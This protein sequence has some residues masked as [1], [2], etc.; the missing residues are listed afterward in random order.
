MRD[1]RK[2]FPV[3][4]IDGMKINK[5]HFIDQDNSV[6]DALQESIA[7]QLSPLRYGVLPLSAAGEDSFNIKIAYDNQNSLRVSVLSCEAITSGGVRISLPGYI[8]ATNSNAGDTLTK[9]FSFSP[10]D[11]EGT[12]WIFLFVHPYEK[13][14]SGSPDLAENPPRFPII[15]P[16]Y[17]MQL[18][19]ENEYKQ[20]A[21]H[22]YA[23]AIG[24]VAV[25]GNVVKIEDEYIPACFSMSAH[26]DLISLHAELDKYASDIELYCSQIIQK[27]FKK[28]QQNEISELVQFLCDRV[29]LYLAQ[30]IT[31]MRWTRLYEPPATI[32]ADISALARVMKNSIDMRIGSG[33]DELMN[34]LTEW[35]ELKQGQLES[36]LA[37]LANISFDNNDINKNIEKVVVFVKVTSHLFGTLNKLEFIG[38][39][40]EI[41]LFIEEQGRHHTPQQESDTKTKRRFFG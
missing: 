22:P 24:K 27:I 4:W 29:I 14:P 10:D 33:K 38:K 26:P 16:T 8:P 3:N 28:K 41:G 18:V 13:Q 36:M 5:N 37:N 11:N 17:S 31:S 2:H 25:N 20:Y 1:Q 21:N 6:S 34:Y 39:K 30:V 9:T 40:K 15:L 35:C 32:L 7:L 19:S 23:L 12:W